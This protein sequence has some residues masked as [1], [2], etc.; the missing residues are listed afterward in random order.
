MNIFFLD[1]DPKLAAQYHCDKHVVKMILE[2]A[3]LLS[4]AHRMIDGEV[5]V[6]VRNGRKI[7]RFKHPIDS[8]D[9][10]L[11]K[12][13]H[14]NHPSAKWAR[15]SKDNYIWLFN[16]FSDL[17]KE[18]T[19]RYGREHLSGI[20]LMDILKNPPVNIPDIGGTAIAQAMPDEYKHSDPV[21]AYRTYYREAKSRMLQYTNRPQPTWI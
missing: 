16:L 15:E 20:K 8:Y 17:C 7:K 18:Y 2:S 9:E 14:A 19:Y 11:Y 4:T 3:Q 12:A 10:V 1:T 13:T 21:I 5:F 6:E